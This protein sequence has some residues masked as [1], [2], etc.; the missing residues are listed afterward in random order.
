[1]AT[2]S[3]AKK[4]ESSAPKPAKYPRHSV[5]KALRIPK[6]IL[7]E[8]G[9]HPS[10]PTQAAGYLGLKTAKGPFAVEIGS[11]KKYGFLDWERSNQPNWH[12]GSCDPRAKKTRSRRTAKPDRKNVV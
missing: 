2:K 10:T 6:A 9:G 11:S 4:L 3:K 5:E 1:M 7:E 8:N 12:A